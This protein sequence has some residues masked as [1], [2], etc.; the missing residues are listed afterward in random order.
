MG[1]AF[2]GR[3][4]AGNEAQQLEKV[5]AS[6]HVSEQ[7]EAVALEDAPPPPA[8]PAPVHN[9][10]DHRERLEKLLDDAGRIAQ[11]LE[12]EAAD[13]ALAENLRLDEKRAAVAK[14]AQAERE[15]ES[16]ARALAQQSETA[17]TLRARTDAEVSAAQHAVSAAEDSVKRRET[18][19]AEAQNVVVQTKSKLVECESRARDAAL[20]A[21]TDAAK[22]QEA[23]ALIATCR[24]AREAAESE[25]R[26]AEAI[27]R[28]ITQTAA[29]LKQLRAA[30]SN[31][32]AEPQV[33]V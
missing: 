31:G 1:R 28:G 4:R 27:A 15:A 8:P 14:L 10:Q 11:L 32:L 29:T 9:G 20:Q 2:G 12:K 25:V 21:E 24:E 33:T 5:L 19:L 7:E 23:N 17:A 22:V 18:L 26:E 6:L 30:G 3:H 16:Q 13:A